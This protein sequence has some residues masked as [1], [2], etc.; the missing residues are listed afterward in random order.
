MK[1]AKLSRT[2]DEMIANDL[3]KDL[4]MGGDSTGL[5]KAIVVPGMRPAVDRSARRLDGPGNEGSNDAE[6][7][8]NTKRT[9]DVFSVDGAG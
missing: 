4:W 3:S 8:N 6:N 2:H 7:N 9:N 1:I 5:A